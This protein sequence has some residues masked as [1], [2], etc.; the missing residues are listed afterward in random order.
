[1]EESLGYRILD[2]V[3]V[4]NTQRYVTNFELENTFDMEKRKQINRTHSLQFKSWVESIDLKF[5]IEVIF[6]VYI[7]IHMQMNAISVVDGIE[8]V[9]PEFKEIQNI[10]NLIEQGKQTKDQGTILINQHI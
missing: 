3:L 9:E 10:K 7:A 8:K 4:D 5:L 2:A 1:M 6:V